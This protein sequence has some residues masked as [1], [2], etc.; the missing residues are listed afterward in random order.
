MGDGSNYNDIISEIKF[1][2]DVICYCLTIIWVYII[3]H[4]SIHS[5]NIMTYQSSSNSNMKL[6]NNAK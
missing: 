5:I 1:G 2:D 4:S 6:W 3:I